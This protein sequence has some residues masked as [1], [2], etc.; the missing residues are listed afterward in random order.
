MHCRPAP[1]MSSGTEAAACSQAPGNAHFLSQRSRRAPGLQIHRGT[2]PVQASSS[3]ISRYALCSNHTQY[4]S[5]QG[6]TGQHTSIRGLKRKQTD[7]QPPSF[8]DFPPVCSQMA[9][10]THGLSAQRSLHRQ[11]SHPR[12]P[13]RSGPLAWQLGHTWAST[14]PVFWRQSTLSLGQGPQGHCFLP[15]QLGWDSSH[16][17]ESPGRNFGNSRTGLPSSQPQDLLG[18][19]NSLLLHPAFQEQ[20]SAPTALSLQVSPGRPSSASNSIKSLAALEVGA[21]GGPGQGLCYT[22]PDQPGN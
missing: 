21:V 17:A 8:A 19:R 6:P 15:G 20:L 2:C 16:R 14:S 11:Y 4:T 18:V 10:D 1:C 12:K 9:T 22:Q 5:S 3:C 7:Q 13:P